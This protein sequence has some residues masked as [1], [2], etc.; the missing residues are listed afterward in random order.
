M[1]FFHSI[2][3]KFNT[4]SKFIDVTTTLS[5]ETPIWPGAKKFR[6]EQNKVD[7]G[8][9]EEATSSRFEMIP[10]NGTHIDAPLHFARGGKAIEALALDMLV[11]PCL[12]V[13]HHGENHIGKDDLISMGFV[14]TKRLLVKSQNSVKVRN[15]TLDEKF[16]SLLP[17]AIEHLIQSGVELLGVDG[18][19]I[20]PFGDLTTSNHLAFCKTGGIIIEVLDLLDVEPGRYGLIALPIKLEGLEGAPARVVLVRPEDVDNVLR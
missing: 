18:L 19:S 8:G 4:F 16:I 1:P 15:R 5:P 11:G 3:D 2:M 20:G 13:E 14:P 9:G 17:D 6:L 7:L 12:V 10:H